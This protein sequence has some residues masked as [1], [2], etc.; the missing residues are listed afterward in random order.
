MVDA[1]TFDRVVQIRVT[2]AEHAELQAVPGQVLL[3]YLIEVFDAE[4]DAWSREPQRPI[5]ASV[6]A[7]A[8]VTAGLDGGRLLFSLIV[9]DAVVGHATEFRERELKIVTRIV[10]PGVLVLADET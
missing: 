8:L 2:P 6:D 9:D 7:G 5:A 4:G 3:A 10:V 1:G